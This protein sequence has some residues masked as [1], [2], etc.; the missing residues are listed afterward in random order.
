M[1]RLKFAAAAGLLVL[2]GNAL[3]DEAEEAAMLAIADAAFDR[4]T[5]DDSIG[6]TDLMIPEA[7]IYIGV[8]EDGKYGVRTRTYQETRDRAMTVDL[9]ERGWDPTV[10]HSG[11][12]GV[13]WYPYDIYINGE[14]SHC[15]VD[16]FNMIRTD[17]GWRVSVLQYNV[18]QPP[19][20]EPHP[21]G[22]PDFE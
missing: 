8:V 4:I 10:M 15:G 1:N 7:M 21:D 16:I 14:W 2:L 19:E 5:A 11:T 13:V 12:I 17:A 9:H 6:L 3:A 22:P 18:Q 20:C